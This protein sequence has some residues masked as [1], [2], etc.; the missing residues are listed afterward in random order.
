LRT[1]VVS[2]HDTDAEVHRLVAYLALDPATDVIGL[3]LA[4]LPQPRRFVTVARAT[5]RHKPIVVLV[6][7]TERWAGCSR[8]LLSANAGIWKQ[9]GVEVVDRVEE[10][11]HRIQRVV[12]Q[13]RSATWVPPDRGP[14][15]AVAGCDLRR[16]R[17]ALDGRSGQ[18]DSSSALDT[19]A[20]EELFAAYGVLPGAGEPRLVA[21]D[22]WFTVKRD[23]CTGLSAR[24]GPR[25]ADP[26]RY[27]AFAVPLTSV[28]TQD[29]VHCAGTAHSVGPE[30]TDA[31]VRLSRV[32]D[33]QP[34][35]MGLQAALGV[36]VAPDTTKVWLGTVRSTE[37][38]PFVRR[39]VPTHDA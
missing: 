38:D 21:A 8:S 30:V 35:I 36:A 37:D 19:A 22:V 14:L 3:E 24:L 5:S 9:S 18:A 34:E 20:T 12:A 6:P 4:H 7:A 39:L 25:D 17:A 27:P 23:P 15:A 1:F 2:G 31:L 13:R 32:A 33:D 28:D 26:D 11:I 16:A 10:F 29:L